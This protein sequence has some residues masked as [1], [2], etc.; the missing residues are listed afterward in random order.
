MRERRTEIH[1]SARCYKAFMSMKSSTASSPKA[2]YTSKGIASGPGEEFPQSLMTCL[3]TA[4]L[5]RSWFLVTRNLPL[6]FS[7]H[8]ILKSPFVGL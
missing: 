8:F 5:G 6:I 7:S 4:L 3:T 1:V 2:L